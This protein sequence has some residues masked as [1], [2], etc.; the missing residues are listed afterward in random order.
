MKEFLR[1]LAGKTIIFILCICSLCATTLGVVQ[2]IL[3]Y[4][5]DYYRIKDVEIN[6]LVL[7][8]PLKYLYVGSILALLFSVALFVTLM[9]LSGRRRGSDE[10]V[11]GP[12]SKIPFDVLLA[13]VVIVALG[14]IFELDRLRTALALPTAVISYV[15]GLAAIL[16]LSMSAASRIKQHTFIKGT[17]IY[18]L[19]MIP[20]KLLIM[21]GRLFKKYFKTWRD[22]IKKI[23]LIA[24]TAIGVFVVTLI[25]FL[26]IAASYSYDE[27]E[28]I[29]FLWVLEK[30]IFV[31]LIL[32]LAV[33][34]RKLQKGGVALAEGDLAYV[35]ETNGMI[36]DFKQHAENLN[37]IALVM[38]RAVEERL[39]SERMKTELITNVS[40][41][42]K[43]PL[44]SII[45]YATLIAGGDCNPEET[46]EYSDVLVRQS[47]KLKRLTEDLVEA[48]KASTGNLDIITAPCEASVF[49][50]QVSGEFEEKLRGSELSLITKLPDK[51]LRIM[52]DGRRMWRIFD[53]LLSNICKYSLP[54]TRVYLTLEEQNSNAVF[55]FKNTSR[56]PL[57]MSS[58]EL[59]ERFTR[60]D[61]SRN[62]EG[63]GLGLSIAKSLTELQG[64]TL[65]VNTDGDLFKV[66]LTFPLIP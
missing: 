11:P 56:D 22:V 66:T 57:D 58:E 9:Y 4:M 31:P 38:N 45:N 12:F 44:T 35:T 59:L 61:A 41:D 55:S 51:E 2:I 8:I 19:L 14:I 46:K 48:S 63:N 42:I 30:L 40:H 28:V 24:K 34:L 10:L 64:G 49:I 43:T 27:F 17:L 20:K 60:G 54:S 52:V 7:G 25:E 15:V 39:K 50:T 36:G 1:S 65:T 29:I 26:V 5:K 47:E 21:L 37:S 33:T 18:M 62:T 13:P 32:Y 3:T 23:P 53:N 16:G 6:F